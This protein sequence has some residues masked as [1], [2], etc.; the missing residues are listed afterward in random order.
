M[1]RSLSQVS[2]DTGGYGASASAGPWHDALVYR[3]ADEFLDGTVP[4]LLDGLDAGERMLAVLPA[5]RIESLRTA[6]G[7]KSEQVGF[8]PTDPRHPA[9]L[10][11]LWVAFVE[12]NAAAGRACRGIGEPVQATA[13]AAEI[14]EAQLHEALANV[15]FPSRARVRLL[16]PYDA[17]AL[18]PV[19]VAEATRSHG[20][21]VVG[22][23]RSP[24]PGF[25]GAAYA[26]A[27]FAEPLPEPPGPAHTVAFGVRELPRLRNTVLRSARSAGIPGERVA[28]LL[29]CVNEAAANSVT[30]GG[31]HGILRLW[32]E[33]TALV[34]EVRDRGRIT[35]PLV[36]RIE[37]D[38]LATGGRGLWTIHRLCDLAQ[39]RS[40]DQ[41]TVVRLHTWL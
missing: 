28:D 38:P 29:W 8:V 19:A 26:A 23:L 13:R 9:R 14:A 32:L 27:M 20:H 25:D 12:R 22:G 10:I 17:E 35:D 16:C 39:V 15:A 2:G 36:G 21:V 4:F 33:A 30:H 6:L 31:G 18:S 11:P 3:G 34:C 40:S 5:P 24:T 41:G 1:P 7:Q 37:P